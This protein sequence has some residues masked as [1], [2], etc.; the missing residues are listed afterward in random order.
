MDPAIEAT[1]GIDPAETRSATMLGLNSVP[2]HELVEFI[3]FTHE[4]PS[5][6]ACRGSWLA[7]EQWGFSLHLEQQFGG[8][9]VQPR[10]QLMFG[11]VH[12][13]AGGCWPCI[14][15]LPTRD[16]AQTMHVILT[17]KQPSLASVGLAPSPGLGPYP[18]PMHSEPG[19][20]AGSLVGCGSPRGRT[21]DSMPA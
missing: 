6:D 17:Y 7:Y 1:L 16:W 9:F 8:G 21:S 5:T 14:G 13:A 10:V 20:P 15:M 2:A 11:R 18:G 19:R 4:H 3:D 12:C